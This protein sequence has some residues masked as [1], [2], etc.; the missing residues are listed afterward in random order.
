MGT[1]FCKTVSMTNHGVPGR[2]DPS[3]E[4]RKLGQIQFRWKISDK[5]WKVRTKLF[6][7]LSTMVHS[8]QTRRS[9]DV[10][11]DAN[12]MLLMILTYLN[13]WGM[14]VERELPFIYEMKAKTDRNQ[15]PVVHSL[16]TKYKHQTISCNSRCDIWSHELTGKHA[17]KA[18]HGRNT[19]KDRSTPAT[20]K[21]CI[22]S[23]Y[24]VVSAS[25]VPGDC[26]SPGRK[27]AF[28]LKSERADHDRYP[29][30]VFYTDQQ[31]STTLVK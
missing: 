6:L 24:F 11:C 9:C 12:W 25:S 8:I 15:L 30:V 28:S 29:F 27:A 3:R 22:P 7:S 18:K 17:P 14:W 16:P 5:H 31:N 21:V 4:K 10:D 23:T 20:E 19:I 2:N 1:T 13:V 26:R